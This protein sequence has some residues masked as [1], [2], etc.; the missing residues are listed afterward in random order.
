MN[1]AFA[2]MSYRKISKCFNA[3]AAKQ[4]S[5]SFRYFYDKAHKLIKKDRM[6]KHISKP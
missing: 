4:K 5:K 6:T 2:T 3:V 1:T